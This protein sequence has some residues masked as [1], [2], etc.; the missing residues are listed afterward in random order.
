MANW[1]DTTDFSLTS[2]DKVFTQDTL[3]SWGWGTTFSSTS[4]TMFKAIVLTQL[5]LSIMTW[6]FLSL[7][8]MIVWN[9][10]DRHQSS[11]SLGWAKAHLTELSRW[12]IPSISSIEGERMLKRYAKVVAWSTTCS[13]FQTSPLGSWSISSKSFW[14]LFD[15]VSIIKVRVLLGHYTTMWPNLWPNIWHLKHQFYWTI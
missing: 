11:L 3:Y 6:Q 13:S 9:I 12:V 15:R 4:V 7:I 14:L 2:M 5:P 1:I 8:L 10:M